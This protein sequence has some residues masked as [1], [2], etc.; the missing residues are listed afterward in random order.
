MHPDTT[1]Q[2]LASL[3]TLGKTLIFFSLLVPSD[4]IFVAPTGFNVYP[5]LNG[6]CSSSFPP[7]PFSDCCWCISLIR[8]PVHWLVKHLVARLIARLNFLF[9]VISDRPVNVE[10]FVMSKC[11]DAH[12]CE[13]LFA[14]AL[15]KLS[16]IINFTLSFIAY[17]SGSKEIECMHGADECLG[18]KQQLCVQ[19]LYPQATFIR[20]LQCQAKHID[21]I[22]NNGKKCAQDVADGRLKWPEVDTCVKSSQAN[23]LFHRSLERTRAASAKKSCTMHLNGKFWC[24]HDG[25]WY[26][27][28][29]GHD[30]KS[31][32]KAICLRYSGPKKPD[33]CN[34]LNWTRNTRRIED[35]KHSSRSFLSFSI[36]C[37]SSLFARKKRKYRTKRAREKKINTLSKFSII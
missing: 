19:H 24:M 33:E 34:T 28:S 15:L 13:T 17:E 22:P 20:F 2:A 29:D 31:F 7:C 23:D 9:V 16:S 35:Q 14:P 10:F 36:C 32:I 11:P 5:W 26:G 12:K 27:C 3:I 18:N 6:F 30:E 4:N 1:H 25:S 21:D 37:S 8:Q